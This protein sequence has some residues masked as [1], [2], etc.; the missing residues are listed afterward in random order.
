AKLEFQDAELP[1]E[2]RNLSGGTLQI[3]RDAEGAAARG[4]EVGGR[5]EL[6]LRPGRKGAPSGAGGGLV[7]DQID[8]EAEGARQFAG[9]R[10]LSEPGERFLGVVAV[11]GDEGRLDHESLPMQP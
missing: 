8:G 5:S 2:R 4:D 3:L 9:G 11:V 10:S 1:C 6:F 7:L